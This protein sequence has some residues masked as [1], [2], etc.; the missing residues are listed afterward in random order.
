M[1]FFCF[2]VACLVFLLACQYNSFVLLSYLMK[3]NVKK[4][5]KR[6]FFGASKMFI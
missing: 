4:K 6:M 2:V 5:Q 1:L 3:I